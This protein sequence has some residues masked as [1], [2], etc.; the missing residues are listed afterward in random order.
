MKANNDT[1]MLHIQPEFVDVCL[2]D[3]SWNKYSEIKS[4]YNGSSDPI[5]GI[6][7]I[8]LVSFAINII[9]VKSSY[10][11]SNLGIHT[12]ACKLYMRLKEICTLTHPKKL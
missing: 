3:R 4:S 2:E 8:N 9:L 10:Q 12:S 5:G 1:T 7:C 6:E 11:L